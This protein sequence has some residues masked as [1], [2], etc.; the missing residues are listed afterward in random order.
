MDGEGVGYEVNR[1]VTSEQCEII[2]EKC[3]AVSGS[4]KCPCPPFDGGKVASF[5]IL[6]CWHLVV[7]SSVIRL[8]AISRERSVLER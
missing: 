5:T 2:E 3:G 7:P 4:R 8:H 6:K 1:S